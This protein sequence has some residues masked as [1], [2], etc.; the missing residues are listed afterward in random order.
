MGLFLFCF[1]I[2]CIGGIG[3]SVTYHRI[4]THRVATL[5][6]WLHKVLI[7]LALPSG[8]PVQWV[9]THRQHHQFT[10]K[11]G[12]PHSPL[13]FG[14]WYAHCGW[15]IQSKN[16]FLTILY[17]F[18]GIFRIYFDAYWRP[19]TNQEFNHRAIDIQNDVFCAFVSQKF[20]YQGLMWT[21]ATI[22]LG[23]SY[24]L[25]EKTGIF[26]L[27]LI[28][29][30]IYNLGDAINSLAHLKGTLGK[31]YHFARN[32]TFLGY[33]A[34]GEGWHANHHDSADKANFGE[35]NEKPDWGYFFMHVFAFFKLLKFNF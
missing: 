19:R 20:V 31:A 2:Y 12:D 24:F 14:F 17:A 16:T 18:S 30:L 9:G 25:F 22:L 11:E 8:T 10:D 27:W 5:S 3:V 23:G 32:N 7:I 1:I 34:F 13:L 33:F 6:P 29:A 28:L 4:L 26:A 15:Y 21:Y 35:Q